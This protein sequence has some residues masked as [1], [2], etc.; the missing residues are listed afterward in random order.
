[1][2]HEIYP[3]TFCP[4]YAD[5]TPVLSDYSLAYLDNYILVSYKNGQV[6]LPKFSDIKSFYQKDITF[7][8]AQSYYLFAVDDLPYFLISLPEDLKSALPVR[9]SLPQEQAAAL[10]FFDLYKF[11]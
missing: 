8:F 3:K 7:L 11:R 10:F 5:K 6:S 2:V 1:M 9:E 4:A